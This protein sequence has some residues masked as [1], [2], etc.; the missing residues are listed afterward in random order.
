MNKGILLLLVV[1]VLL[2]ACGNDGSSAS[3]TAKA[4]GKATVI[5]AGVDTA[6]GG[7]LQIRAARTNGDFEKKGLDVQLANFAYGIDTI[8]ALLTKQTDTGLAADYAL[9]NSLSKGDLVI[10]SS[11][12]GS[13]KEVNSLDYSEILA[14]ADVKSA[15][16]LKGKKIGVAKGTVLEYFWARYFEYLNISES[17]VHYIP[18]STPDE[19]IVGVKKGD[20]DAV[21]ASGALLEK[22]KSIEGVHSLDKL[23]SVKDLNITSYLVADRQFAEENQDA[24]AQLIAGINEGIAYVKENPEGTADI[25]YD[26]LK[27]AKEDVLRDL[28]RQNFTIGFKQQDYDH[29]VELKKYLVDKGIIKQDYDLD[30]K[31][32]LE[33]A[34]KVVSEQVTYKK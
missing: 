4:E 6:A 11:L 15:D 33:P 12:T 26:E 2:A 30:A 13:S 1:S 24:I 23:S 3:E 8:N 28:K 17:D 20:I 9:L 22:F 27:V 25:A 19:A 18:Y 16:D 21:I 34:K 14:V 29:L 5:R 32:F 31:L 7:S 10:V